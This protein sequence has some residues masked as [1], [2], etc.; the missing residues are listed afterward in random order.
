VLGDKVKR[1]IIELA[2][3]KLP[4][5]VFLDYSALTI[6]Y[7]AIKTRLRWVNSTITPQMYVLP[8]LNEQQSTNLMIFG[9]C[10]TIFII[11][12]KKLF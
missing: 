3:W 11:K 6:L 1:P 7:P 2:I 12:Y 5:S 8:S 4:V 10:L 9:L